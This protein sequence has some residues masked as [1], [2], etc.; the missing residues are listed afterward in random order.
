MRSASATGL[1]FLLLSLL[2]LLPLSLLL[3]LL[4]LF[5]PRGIVPVTISA[6]FGIRMNTQLIG[7]SPCSHRQTLSESG[8]LTSF[9]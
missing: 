7:R 6:L 4:L 2:L 8:T 9:G 5:H 3:L 1:L